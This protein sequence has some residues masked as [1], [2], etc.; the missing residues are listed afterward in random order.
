MA[1]INQ[2]L[3]FEPILK[4][5]I[6]GGNKLTSILNKKSDLENLGE[7][8]EVSGVENEVSV[9]SNGVLKGE[10]LDQ[11]IKT[12][13]SDFVGDKVYQ[14]F[15]EKFPLLIKFIDAKTD[16]SIQVHPNDIQAKEK[17]NSLGKTEMWYVTQADKNASLIVGFKKDTT[18]EEYVKHLND[19]SL[20][21]I[22]NV[23]KVQEGDVYFIPA[24][25][26]HAIGAG[27]MVAEIQ[28]TSDVTYRIYDWQRTDSEGNFRELHTK[29]ALQVID[30]KPKKNY[31]TNYDVLKNDVSSLVD[32][33]YF[34]TNFLKL[35]K[36]FSVNHNTKDSFVV[37]MCVKGNA[38]FESDFS[39]EMIEKGETLV[40][41]ACLKEFII[42]PLGDV[43]L[44]EVYIK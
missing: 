3:R 44:L 7:S 23:D 36:L 24:G 31:K 20:L 22:L 12:Y 39:K 26:V 10:S 17:H 13:S 1:K 42:K 34:T 19:N 29:D 37:Y 43:E 27:V 30:F 14:Q 2:F 16:L 25:R 4:Q 21:E 40:V 8:W 41:P 32:C 6:W 35:D 28:E 5:K 11:L 33:K 38:V 18:E 15:G 9:V